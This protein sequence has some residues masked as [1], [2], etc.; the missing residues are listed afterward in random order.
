MNQ[1]SIIKAMPTAGEMAKNNFTNKEWLQFYKNV[2]NRQAVAQA[3]DVE[4]DKVRK[5][6][7]PEQTVEDDG[8]LVTVKVRLENRKIKIQNSLDIL[9][10]IAT[11]EKI[12]DD[13][14]NELV[15]SKEALK[16]DEDMLPKKEE[17]KAEETPVVEK[18]KEQEMAE[19]NVPVD[20]E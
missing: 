15:F 12:E 14:F 18:T 19:G 7:N 6:E 8:E 11:L 4:T 5:A 17:P 13:K 16:V 10:A 9:S 2:W 1:D 3:I 20:P